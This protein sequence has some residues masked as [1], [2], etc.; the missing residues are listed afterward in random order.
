MELEG[1]HIVVTGGGSGM[2]RAMLRRFARERPR[3]LVVVDHDGPAAQAVADEVGGLAFDADVGREAAI[4]HV[5]E[6][7]QEAHGPIDVWCSNAGLSGPTA[8]PEAPDHLWQKLWDVHVMSHVWAARALLPGMVE[9]GEGYLINTASAAALLMSPGA[10]PYTVT[11]HAALS[12]AENLAVLYG[13]AGVRVSCLCPQLVATGMTANLKCSRAG[14]AVLAS[15]RCLEPEQVAEIV[16]DALRGE[17]F[18][19]TPHEEVLKAAR[20]RAADHDRWLESMRE[21]WRRTASAQVG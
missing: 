3:N 2:G 5:I 17:R 9:K 14:R 1:R 8:G 16:V 4:L 15:G 6:Q 11:K 7:A 21:T 19:I 10:V 20:H 12:L 13:D 18:L